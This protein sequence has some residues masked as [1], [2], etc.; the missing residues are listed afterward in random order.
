MQLQIIV[1]IKKAFAPNNLIT[2]NAWSQW[3]VSGQTGNGRTSMKE[4]LGRHIFGGQNVLF[5]D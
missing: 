4:F 5:I 1:N 3:S 2:I